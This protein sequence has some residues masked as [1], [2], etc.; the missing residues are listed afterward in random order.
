MRTLED[1]L[2]Y[3]IKKLKRAGFKPVEENPVKVRVEHNGVTASYWV[4]TGWY[5]G[6]GMEPGR[7]I[8]ELINKLKLRS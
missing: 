3:V 4:T 7:G 1:R 8:N 2:Q 6:Q 5:S